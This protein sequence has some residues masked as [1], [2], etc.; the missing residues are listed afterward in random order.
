MRTQTERFVRA[1]HV[2]DVLKAGRLV[3][4]IAGH[5]IFSFMS[6]RLSMP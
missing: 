3:V 5:K 2:D 4:A 6:M 1:A